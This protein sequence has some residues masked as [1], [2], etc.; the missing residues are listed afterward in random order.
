EKPLLDVLFA[1]PGL[2]PGAQPSPPLL[3]EAQYTQPAIF[4][5]EYALAAMW[6]SWG[7]EPAIVLGHSVGEYAAG[8]VAGLFSLEDG[9]R[10]IAERGRLSAS[11][12]PGGAMAA[13][14]ADEARVAQ[15]LASGSASRVSIACVNGPGNTV[16]SGE[17]KSVE[18]LL[19]RLA[20]EGVNSRPLRVSH[21]FHSPLVEPI[22]TEFET[23][24]RT[25]KFAEPQLAIVSNVTGNLASA[26]LMTRPDY[27]S[28]HLREPVRFAD[29]IL[30]I[31][32]MGFNIFLEIG[33]HPVLTGMAMSGAPDSRM[34]WAGSLHRERSDW[35]AL[36]ESMATLYS[37]GV[38]I[39]WAGVHAGHR[40]QRV[41]LPTYPFQRSRYWLEN[42]GGPAKEPPAVSH[43]ASGGGHPLLGQRL[44]SPALTGVVFE[45]ELGA[46]R[47]A[48]LNDHCIFGRIIMPSPAYIEMALAA[49]GNL[50]DGPADRSGPCEVS[51]LTIREPLILPEEG[52]RRIQTI[53]DARSTHEMDFRICSSD[54]QGDLESSSKS[55]WRTHA[56]GC[57]RL[58]E[59]VT[60]PSGALW[61]RAEMWERCPHELDASTFYE[62]LVGLGLQFG[63]R[64]R[65]LVR[66]R[67]GKGEAIGEVRL[68]GSLEPESSRY[69]VHPALLDSCFHL[70]GAALP[71]EAPRDAYLL[72]GLER[73]TLH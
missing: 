51:N 59:S 28:R 15:A 47:P 71:P 45:L 7:V 70:L 68:P 6:R 17:R 14:F 36:S 10:L 73:F 69:R 56:T 61:N 2:T 9:L 23:I 39:D 12:S 67:Q 44:N 4:A 57:V 55:L 41:S 32:K 33:P 53:L 38:G 3:D 48:F 29:S 42:A 16:I 49:A 60:V 58:G 52:G 35:E 25:F 62:S 26:G 37:A 11:L 27:W 54:S 30:H 66:I 8:C 43:R 64:F 65:G 5:L 50:S 72:I 19:A 22:V 63:E 13:V 40:R 1:E 24:A 21:A 31:A 46:E 18:A 20:A 34:V